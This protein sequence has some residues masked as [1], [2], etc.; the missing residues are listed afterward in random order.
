MHTYAFGSIVRGDVVLG[1]DVDLLAVVN[2]LD[3]RFDPDV[4]SIYS[5]LRIRELWREGNPF[6][7]HLSLESKLLYSSTGSNFLEELGRPAAYRRCKID[8]EKFFALF[9]EASLAVAAGT[10]SLTFNLSIVFLSIRNFATCYSLGLMGK[11]NFSRTSAISLGTDSIQ[12]TKTT[13]SVL[14]RA[15]ILSTRGFGSP[16]IEDEAK[17][18]SEEFCKIDSWM[19]E[20]LRKVRS[21][22]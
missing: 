16:I 8:C 18:A 5:Y 15:R 3:T 6:A 11:P 4:F 17:F 13:F 22:G 1:S 14:E 20:L 21:N 2:G 9:H 12:L 19:K 10:N 7:W